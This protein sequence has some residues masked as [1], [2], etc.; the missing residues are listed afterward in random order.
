MSAAFI[1]R[2]KGRFSRDSIEVFAD[3]D[4]LEDFDLDFGA[5][6]EEIF[7]R[8]LVRCVG[9]FFCLVMPVQWFFFKIFNDF[10]KIFKNQIAIISLH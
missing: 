2:G 4:I 9:F 1:L 8:F 10:Y 5:F 3:F 7:G 6:C